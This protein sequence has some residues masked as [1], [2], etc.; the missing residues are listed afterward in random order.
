MLVGY[1]GRHVGQG[2]RGRVR[3]LGWYI[4]IAMY[5]KQTEVDIPLDYAVC[6]GGVL[7]S[8]L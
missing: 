3:R 5:V 4:S 7:S 1:G 8:N 6:P 2:E